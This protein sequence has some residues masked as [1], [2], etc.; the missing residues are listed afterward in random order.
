MEGIF[1][2]SCHFNNVFLYCYGWLTVKTM[3]MQV[4]T[5]PKVT[6]PPK[7]WMGFSELVLNK[8]PIGCCSRTSIQDH[9]TQR[10]HKWHNGKVRCLLPNTPTI[11]PYV[12]QKWPLQT[13]RCLTAAWMSSDFNGTGHWPVHDFLS[14]TIEVVHENGGSTVQNRTKYRWFAQLRFNP[15]LFLHW[16]TCPLIWFLFTWCSEW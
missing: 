7:S 6:D 4:V 13:P 8:L 12:C 3:M 16:R 5:S 9:S 10:Q 1:W 11:L 2:S 15:V 14:R